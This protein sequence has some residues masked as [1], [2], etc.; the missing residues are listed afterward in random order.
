MQWNGRLEP[1][2]VVVYRTDAGEVPGSDKNIRNRLWVH[3]DG[4]VVRQEV[5]L[6]DHNLLFTR[7]TEQD[8][9]KLRDE[10]KEI[11]EAGL[12]GDNHDRVRPGSSTI[13]PDG[14]GERSDA[15]HSPGRAFR[16]AGP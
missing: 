10:H 5:L 12:A 3:R 7:L 1:T 4:T 13:R 6:G 11:P 14:G 9:V 15:D 16:P 8:A 2:W